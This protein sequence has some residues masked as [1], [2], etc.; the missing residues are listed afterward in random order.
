MGRTYVRAGTE[1]SSVRAHSA[2]TDAEARL[3]RA[4]RACGDAHPRRQARGSVGRTLAALRSLAQLLCV[5]QRLQLLQRP[6]LDLAYALAG[7][8]E[9][10]SDLLQGAR[11]SS[12]DAVAKLDHLAL[13]CRQRLQH[14]RNPLSPQR[15]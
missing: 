6:V 8:V 3:P 14:P 1:S 11:P 13:A 2:G 10:L 7:D 12:H 5:G 9:R 4:F 15:S